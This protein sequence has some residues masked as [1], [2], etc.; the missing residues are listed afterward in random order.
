MSTGALAAELCC[1]A[2]CPSVLSP[3]CAVPL[4]DGE[5]SK[6]T[7][8]ATHRGRGDGFSADPDSPVGGFSAAGPSRAALQ[9]SSNRSGVE[10]RLRRNRTRLCEAVWVGEAR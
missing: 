3:L 2:R 6:E 5:R 4:C 10:E 8:A 7:R 1:G 9:T